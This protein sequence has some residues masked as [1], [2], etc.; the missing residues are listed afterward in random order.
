[1]KTSSAVRL[2]L[3]NRP[4]AL[5]AIDEGIVNY[6]ALARSVKRAIGARSQNAVKAA[7]IR[8]AM[9]RGSRMEVIE[10]RALS[11]IKENRIM[12]LDNVSV[13][14]SNKK[15]SMANEAEVKMDFY[16]V[17]L[18]RG[19]AKLT[20]EERYSVVE[21]HE[22]CSMVVI[23]SGSNIEST[24]GVTAFMTSLLAE[25][26][27]NIV[28]IVSCYTETMIVVNRTDAVASYELLSGAMHL[29]E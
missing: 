15:L 3:K 2:Y 21:H 10:L 29:K 16:Y 7:V 14:I 8:Y 28:E 6:S 27:I 19:K 12:L 23:Y 11:V 20:K 25:Y 4:Y 18:V 5:A 26:G 24:S 13:I 17:Y 9:E 1:M 22:N